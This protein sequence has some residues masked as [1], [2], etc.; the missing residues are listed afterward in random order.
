[1]FSFRGP[2]PALLFHTQELWS[3]HRASLTKDET[4]ALE[5]PAL[6]ETQRARVFRRDWDHA[7]WLECGCEDPE[8]VCA[9]SPRLDMDLLADLGREQ[10][11]RE[12]PGARVAL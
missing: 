3:I 5:V 11:H 1:M 9:V 4:G 10:L 8:S 7:R 6:S 2:P 12:P